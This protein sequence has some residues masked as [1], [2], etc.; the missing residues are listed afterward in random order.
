MV[1]KRIKRIIRFETAYGGHELFIVVGLMMVF[2]TLLKLTGVIYINS[3]WYWFIAG[4]GLVTEGM[5]SMA[6]QK[7][8]NRKYK[9]IERNEGE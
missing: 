5:I 3:D 7:R 8:F 9:I 2:A 6:K 1:T 4:L